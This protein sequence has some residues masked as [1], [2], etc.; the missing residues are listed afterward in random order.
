[1]SRKD[2]ATTNGIGFTPVLGMAD[3]AESETAGSTPGS[4]VAPSDVPEVPP[5]LPS[6]EVVALLLDEP[7]F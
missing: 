2:P 7:L 3:A 1:M 5:E 6:A 4:D